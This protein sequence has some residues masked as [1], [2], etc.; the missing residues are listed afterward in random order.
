MSCGG[1][2]AQACAPRVL[3]ERDEYFVVPGTGS[4]RALVCKR[5]GQNLLFHPP[6]TPSMRLAPS[7]LRPTFLISHSSSLPPARGGRDAPRDRERPRESG[8]LWSSTHDRRVHRHTA[9]RDA[10]RPLGGGLASRVARLRLAAASHS[11]SAL[12]S[13]ASCVDGPRDVPVEWRQ[14][15]RR[16]CTGRPAG[17]REPSRRL[18]LSHRDQPRRANTTSPSPPLPFRIVESAS[19]A[20]SMHPRTH[21]LPCLLRAPP[22]PRHCPPSRG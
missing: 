12:S 18:H 10:R 19:H 16:L 4:N 11:L 5:S 6:R 2:C 21:T 9:A 7:A 3:G 22:P 8:G 17:P 15:A 13:R 20:V 14:V 1:S